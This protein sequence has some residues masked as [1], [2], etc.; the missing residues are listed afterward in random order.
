MCSYCNA[1]S[2]DCREIIDHIDAHF[3][4]TNDDNIEL[5]PVNLP[6]PSPVNSPLPSPALPSP[7][8]VSCTITD[9]KM[10]P[11]YDETFYEL[12]NTMPTLKPLDDAD[13]VF[14]VKLDKSETTRPH[15]RRSDQLQNNI[16]ECTSTRPFKISLVQ[17]SASSR[18][19]DVP[20]A[21][22]IE[23][24]TLPPVRTI[25]LKAPVSAG[26]IGTNESKPSRSAGWCFGKNYE[27]IYKNRNAALTASN[28]LGKSH[29]T[30]GESHCTPI[31]DIA[32]CY[33]CYVEPAA[34]E[35]PHKCKE[36]GA[37]LPD[38]KAYRTHVIRTHHHV[39]IKCYQCE[40]EPAITNESDP[41]RH[42]C[43]FCQQWFPNHVEFQ[44]HFK[45]A[46]N[47]NVDTYF[48]WLSECREYTCY[49]CE[50]NLKQREY[51]VTHMKSHFDKYLEHQCHTCGLRVRTE[52]VLKEHMKRHEEKASECDLCNKTFPNYF[53]MRSHRLCHTS[54]LK[55][56]CEICSKGFKLS[57]YLSRHMAV[58]K[59]VKIFCRYCDASFKFSTGR[60]AHEKSQ[61]NVV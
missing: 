44:I 45:D 57:K 41:R 31:S 27:I 29:S 59:E 12:T 61:H 22:K 49:I 50:R 51:L 54:E 9:I 39:T 32:K 18:P 16:M 34:S 23:L 46:H 60:R 8:F 7:E 42:K 38:H 56:V 24:L 37:I 26:S 4:T 13:K 11:E 25:R 3:D 5:S 47:E 2:E 30:T 6:L 28:D 43:V 21:P 52:S 58:H 1:F 48:G 15:K 55:Y 35:R 36:C 10:E 40:S 19:T 53:R 14:P 20:K 33:Q 17:S